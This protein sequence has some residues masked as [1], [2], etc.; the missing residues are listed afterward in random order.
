MIEQELARLFYL[1]ILKIEKHPKLDT[2]GQVRALYELVSKVFSEATKVENFFFSTLFARISYAGHRFLI[3]E[4]I[5]RL[6]HTFRRAVEQSWRTGNQ[7][8]SVEHQKSLGLLAVSQSVLVLSS[9]AFPVELIEILPKIEDFLFQKPE[10]WDFRQKIRVVALE[11]DAQNERLICRDEQNPNEKVLVLYNLPDRNDSFLPTIEAIRQVFGFPVTLNLLEVDIDKFG[12]YRPRAFV[13]E[14]DLLM[15]VSAVSETFSLSG[16]D[17]QHFLVK[18]F[19]PYE[20][21][22]A[23]LLGNVAN[24]FLDELMH[25]PEADF[26]I[27]IRQAFLLDPLVFSTLN[28]QTVSEIN[29]KAQ[30]HFDTLKNMVK[31][32]FATQKIV[33]DDCLLEPSFFSETYGLQGRLDVFCKNLVQPAIIELKSGKPFA[34]NSYGI[35]VS[36]FTQT[37]L[38]DLLIKDVFAKQL[39]PTNY[40][41]YSGEDMNPLRFAPVVQAQQMEAIQV[42]NQLVALER[43]MMNILP[44]ASNASIFNKISGKNATGFVKRDYE[45]F[46]KTLENLDLTERKYF[47]SFVGFLA[48]EQ[49]LAK[50]GQPNSERASGHAALWLK[51]LE[52][53]NA[54]FEILSHLQL[55]ENQAFASDSFLV[56]ERSKFTNRLA[57]FRVGD[58]AV[59][60]PWR[61]AGNSV[62]HAQVIKCTITELDGAKVRVSLRARQS[63][64][65]IFDE[66]IF[67]NLE[68][69]MMDNGFNASYKSLFEFANSPKKTRDLL[70]ARRAPEVDFTSKNKEKS[71]AFQAIEVGATI[72][73]DLS[74]DFKKDKLTTEQRRIF[75]KIIESRDY[76]LLWGPPGTGKTSVML[77]EIVGHFLEKTDEN[78]LLLAYTNRAVDE[79][80]EAIESLGTFAAENYIRIGSRHATAARF[81]GKLMREKIENAKKRREI[82]EVL[83]NHRI[84]V[85][86]VASFAGQT[87]LLSLKKFNR[88][89][90]D[91]ASQILEPGLLGLLTRFEHFTLI[92][93]HKQLPAVSAQN[94]KTAKI[95]D[96]SLQ[97]IGLFDLRDSLFER[98]YRQ[99]QAENWHW[100]FDRLSHQGR[101]HADIMDFPNR[102]FYGKFLKILPSNRAQTIELSSDFS[103]KTESNW[104]RK[105]TEKRVIFI[106]TQID[107]QSLNGKTNQH[108][109]DLVYQI[110]QFFKEKYNIENRKWQANSLGVITPWRAQ[111]GQII[112]IFDEKQSKT[113]L[114]TTDLTID[115]VERYQ[116]GA[117]EIIVISLCV[118]HFS[119]LESL[120]SMNSEGVDRKLNVALTRARE[121]VIILGN[122]MILRRDARY[123]DLIERYKI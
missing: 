25:N 67:W 91:E 41:L 63:N 15:D 55:V 69:D 30:K 51:G 109:A 116:G 98:L 106:P 81:R 28:D 99:C 120:I 14:P 59:L 37:L 39:I 44:G 19:L 66:A 57:N 65:K 70:L 34:P 29:A 61:E 46:E 97:K 60:W 43:S 2:A 9:A 48:R 21:T 17:P 18:K 76:F 27:L 33:A 77:R 78:I 50:I 82:V 108:E 26:K 117:R 40:I 47:C 38:Y 83:A 85:G 74:T 32:G 89:I 16:A 36:H 49:I 113:A 62:L 103:E 79:I 86:T 111:I 58:I 112:S 121:H 123:A 56:F 84:F 96:E 101:M 102:H 3:S 94:A 4:E 42:R 104:L 118:N 52:E 107:A 68:H 54:T 88:L 8:I 20:K 6:V 35:G 10:T 114:K 72:D 93:D 64:L 105:L 53:K 31:T 24:F 7:R 95:E 23:I 1:E 13:V 100:A 119:Q 115:T 73:L 12:N 22:P 90:I 11:D 45:L 92:G 122:E 5:L 71:N 110:T 87:E 80:C 75:E